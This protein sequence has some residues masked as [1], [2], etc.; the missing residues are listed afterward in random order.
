MKHLFIVNPTAG[1]RD[2]TEDVRRKV[3][4]AFE[5]RSDS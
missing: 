5:G 4:A 2:S 1:K 3:E